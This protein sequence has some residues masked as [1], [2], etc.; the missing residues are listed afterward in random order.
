[1]CVCVA[2]NGFVGY[3]DAFLIVSIFKDIFIVTPMKYHG[4]LKKEKKIFN[5]EKLHWLVILL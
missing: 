4:I 1:M 5:G 3:K 2:L